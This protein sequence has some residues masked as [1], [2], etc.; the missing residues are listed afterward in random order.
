MTPDN[1]AEAATQ[2]SELWVVLQIRVEFPITS[3]KLWKNGI[4]T[5]IECR[6]RLQSLIII[7]LSIDSAIGSF[8]NIE[9]AVLFHNSLFRLR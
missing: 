1:K 3:C 4:P 5:K 8:G 9:V 7:W 2:T 6:S